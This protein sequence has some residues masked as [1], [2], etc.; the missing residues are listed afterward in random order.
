[1]TELEAVCLTVYSQAVQLRPSPQR[2]KIIAICVRAE[3]R[4]QERAREAAERA[5]LEGIAA[6]VA[7]WQA[8]RRAS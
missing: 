2:D 8:T 3:Q 4:R 1:M 5:E 6:G 7:M